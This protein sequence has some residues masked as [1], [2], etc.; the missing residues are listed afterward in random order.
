MLRRRRNRTA[1]RIIRKA[2][3]SPE[4]IKSM[5]EAFDFF[6]TIVKAYQTDN[7]IVLNAVIKSLERRV[8]QLNIQHWFERMG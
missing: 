6:D 1:A 8:V 5:C 3:S 7:V 4:F 2:I